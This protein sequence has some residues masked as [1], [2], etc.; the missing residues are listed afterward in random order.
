MKKIYQLMMLALIGVA[1]SS[2]VYEHDPYYDAPF[3][4]TW[5]SVLYGEGNHE[6]DLHPGEWHKYVF[7][8]DG[9]GAYTQADGLR[10]KFYWDD[11]AGRKLVLRHSD[12]LLETLYYDFDGR[13]MLM[14]TRHDFYTYYV[15]EPYW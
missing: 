4:G 11:Y 3:L 9:T 13:F 7:Y 8:S 14:S 15:Y 1:F 12:G 2:C 10:T 5:E 6:Y